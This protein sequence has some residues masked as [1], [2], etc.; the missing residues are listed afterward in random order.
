M[1]GQVK[2]SCNGAQR[3]GMVRIDKNR[4]DCCVFAKRKHSGS[5]GDECCLERRYPGDCVY[6]SDRG[7]GALRKRSKLALIGVEHVN[8]VFTNRV[9]ADYPTG[10][11]DDK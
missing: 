7:R 4:G 2:N 9:P 10:W 6:V 11:R 8:V 1:L 5:G 3:R